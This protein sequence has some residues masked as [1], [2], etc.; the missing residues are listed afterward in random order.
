MFQ[1]SMNRRAFLRT[2]G[3][4]AAGVA[5]AGASTARAQDG[6]VRGAWADVSTDT[7][8]VRGGPGTDEPA[9][10]RLLHGEPARLLA[11]SSDGSW[12]RVSSSDLVG[13]VSAAYLQ[14]QAGGQPDDVFDL[15]LT[16]PF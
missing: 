8:N 16:F 1:H 5:L 7:L 12:W 6:L 10:G 15:D 13:W 3:L 4:T 11:P 2:T 9:V 14:P